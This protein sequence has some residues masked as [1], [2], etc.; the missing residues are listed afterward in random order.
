MKF[1]ES[2]KQKFYMR[3]VYINQIMKPQIQNN[4]NYAYFEN[5]R[6]IIEYSYNPTLGLNKKDIFVSNKPVKTFYQNFIPK[7]PNKYK[8]DNYSYRKNVIGSYENANEKKMEK[9]SQ[10]NT[11]GRNHKKLHNHINDRSLSENKLKIFDQTY[12]VLKKKEGN[13]DTISYLRVNKSNNNGKI[14]IQEK[15]DRINNDPNYNEIKNKETIFRNSINDNISS[16]NTNSSNSLKG[17]LNSKKN[18]NNERNKKQS[19]KFGKEN[20]YSE[21]NQN[22]INQLKNNTNMNK[23][24]T[25]SPNNQH[26]DINNKNNENINRKYS[27]NNLSGKTNI[28]SYKTFHQ[29]KNQYC[30]SVDKKSSRNNIDYKTYM[31]NYIS[32]NR[33]RDEN[34]NFENISTLNSPSFP[35]YSSIIEDNSIN[36]KNYVWIK[37]NIKNNKF[38]NSIDNN[39]VYKYDKSPYNNKENLINQN[40]LNF[41]NNITNIDSSFYNT[42]IV[43]PDSM[44]KKIKVH[45]ENNLFE[46]SAIIIQSVFRGFLLKK[47]FDNFYYNYKYYYN[48]GIEI[49]ELILNYFFKKNINLIEEKQKFLNYLL[50]LKKAKVLSNKNRTKNKINQKPKSYKNFK[51]VNSPYSLVEHNN[52][53]KS[54]K[55]YQ[56]L[57]L[58]KEIGERFN[59]VEENSQEKNIEKK[60]KDNLNRIN[61]KLNKL[62]ME[63]N[64]LKDIN[65]KNLI[66]ENR[67]KEMSKDNKKKD[68][69]INIITNDNKTLA[70]KLKLIQDKYNKLQ[71]QNQDYINYNSDNEQS[72][73]N[74]GID[75]FEEYRNLFMELLV[76]KIHEKNYL[77]VLRKYFHKFKTVTFAVNSKENT[78]ELLKKEKLKY[79]LN[80]RKTNEYQLL[81]H[82]LYKFYYKTKLSQKEFDNRN[83]KLKSKLLN[84]FKTKENSYKSYLKTYFNK[85]YYKGIIFQIRK[86]KNVNCFHLNKYNYEKIKRLLKALQKRKDNYLKNIK[87]EY[88]MK[89][90]LYTKVLALKTLINDKRRK[91]RQKQKLKK[92]TENETTN[93]YLTNNKILHFGKSNIYILNKD[94]EKQLLI[95]LDENNQNYFSNK[96]NFDINNKFGNVVQATKKLGEIFYK[97]AQHHRLLEKNINIKEKFVNKIEPKNNKD[98]SD[99][100]NVE[101]EE[102][103]GDSF[104]I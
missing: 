13:N 8:K 85:F 28:K 73:K 54:Y 90:H 11:L 16:R 37:K 69:I 53:T 46:Q 21:C 12:T 78:E 92:K 42:E 1:K 82:N 89:W 27:N 15:K 26:I 35:S 79:F 87:R 30:K 83:N 19:I 47:K 20:Y 103:S 23:A 41:E 67:Y 96:E 66:K 17:I 24:Y 52:K 81:Y 98:I 62:I 58:H 102:D 68:D 99:N 64:V 104:G 75:L 32:P 25:T 60:Y 76:N 72:N 57:F 40:L 50:S 49:L 97:A 6:N 51:T 18:F 91:K 93:K 80:I 5:P 101:E 2:N 77:S 33:H 45:K 7:P 10:S 65:Q 56:D 34:K 74:Y 55:F 84:I 70:R 43:Y 3:N 88:F 63:N 59:I 29:N 9:F 100:N 14:M 36:S 31:N 95:S 71:I 22:S 86:E 94:K 4:L 39:Y 61:I 44:N 38:Y 48:K